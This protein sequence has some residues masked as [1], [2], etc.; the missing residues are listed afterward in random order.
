MYAALYLISYL[1]YRFDWP[2]FKQELLAAIPAEWKLDKCYAL[3]DP[4]WSWINAQH[5][6]QLRTKVAQLVMALIGT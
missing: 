5:N 6:R 1:H 3:Y 2:L 4:V